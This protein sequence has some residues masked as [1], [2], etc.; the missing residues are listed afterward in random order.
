MNMLINAKCLKI[1]HFADNETH[2][3]NKYMEEY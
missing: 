1:R 2:V 3:V